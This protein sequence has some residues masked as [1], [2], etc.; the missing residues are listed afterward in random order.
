MHCEHWAKHE[1]RDQ[2]KILL[3]KDFHMNNILHNVGLEYFN[4]TT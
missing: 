4:Y 3:Q 2:K 1:R